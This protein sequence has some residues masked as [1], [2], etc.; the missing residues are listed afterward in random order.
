MHWDEDHDVVIRQVHRAHVAQVTTYTLDSER[1][2]EFLQIDE[3]DTFARE[4]FILMNATFVEEQNE[5]EELVE[6]M[7][8]TVED[9]GGKL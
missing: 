2:V 5:I 7:E 8:V 9:Q 6:T 4:E 1:Y 3:D